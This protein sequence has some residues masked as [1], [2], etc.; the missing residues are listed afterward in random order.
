MLVLLA[1][2]TLAS[3]EVHHRAAPHASPGAASPTTGS[4]PGAPSG[5]TLSAPGAKAPVPL[6]FGEI[7]APGSDLVL[8]E[9]AR[10]LRGR[11]VRME[12]YAAEL[13]DAP[14][15]AFWLVPLPVRGD[16]SGAGV[17][18]LPPESVLVVVRS[19]GDRPIRPAA[20]GLISVSGVLEAGHAA[21]AG[22]SALLR[23]VLDRAP[24][25][26]PAKPSKAARNARTPTKLAVPAAVP[27]A[28]PAAAP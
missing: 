2:V 6:A 20:P 27:R 15:G 1:L 21:G 13:E 28:I 18:D 24:A 16:E 10:S 12:G 9:K 22:Q 11:R 3:T 26:S 25:R 4:R 19:A 5:S 8:S 14:A 23:I 7:F 17:G